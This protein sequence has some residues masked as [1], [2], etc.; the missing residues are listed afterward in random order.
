MSGEVS[1]VLTPVFVTFFTHELR[2]IRK[3]GDIDDSVINAK[4][5]SLP[6]TSVLRIRLGFHFD[7]G[8]DLNVIVAGDN[9]VSVYGDQVI[10]MLATVLFVPADNTSKVKA[11]KGKVKV[12]Y[13][14]AEDSDLSI[15]FP[16]DISK[17]AK[18]KIQNALYRMKRDLE[19]IWFLHNDRVIQVLTP[20]DIYR[21]R[22]VVDN[23]APY[24][25]VVLQ[26]YRQFYVIY[27]NLNC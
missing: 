9:F 16:S 14:S 19:G 17:K 10:P 27:S 25:F 3:Y 13:K 11:V 4:I 1:T 18:E 12:V 2:T 20:F 26:A 15:E 7:K 23:L 24:D 6:I 22:E 5:D 21:L 8:D